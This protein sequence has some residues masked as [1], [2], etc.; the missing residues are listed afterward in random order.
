MYRSHPWYISAGKLR[1]EEAGGEATI[2]LDGA[3]QATFNAY[4]NG[5]IHGKLTELL[6]M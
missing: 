5:R 2:L 4:S 6:G 1:V 3:G